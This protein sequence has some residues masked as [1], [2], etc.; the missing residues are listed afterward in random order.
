MSNKK[1]KIEE[2]IKL[3]ENNIDLLITTNKVYKKNIN[4]LL[5][6]VIE[7]EYSNCFE[8]LLLLKNRDF[9]NK[10]LDIIILNKE[11]A[12]QYI[13][14]LHSKTDHNIQFY[15]FFCLACQKDLED[16]ICD[17]MELY[18]KRPL[19]LTTLLCPLEEV[20]KNDNLRMLKK[21]FFYKNDVYLD[22][23]YKRLCKIGFLNDSVDCISFIIDKYI[24]QNK[25]H[26][27]YSN[28]NF[29]RDQFLELYD[30]SLR[31]GAWNS[32]KGLSINYNE[33][34]KKWDPK[35]PYLYFEAFLSNKKRNRE[36]SNIRKS[37]TIWYH[38]FYNE[39]TL[40]WN[41]KESNNEIKQTIHQNLDNAFLVLLKFEAI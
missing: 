38:F 33:Y 12:K 2:L 29:F 39:H 37:L 26:R 25:N 36:S 30:M 31:L 15:R 16:I 7:K 6:F 9:T 13:I 32:T 41:F 4:E 19:P 21:L 3:S 11:M 14:F 22:I 23:N 18:E 27:N 24:K 5:S 20:I 35:V 1:T 10:E 8:K 28:E 40:N 17:L 34:L